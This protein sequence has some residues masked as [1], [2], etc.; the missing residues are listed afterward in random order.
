M[1][2]SSGAEWFTDKG[3]KRIYSIQLD[4]TDVAEYIGVQDLK[5]FSFNERRKR[6]NNV[7]DAMVVAYMVKEGAIDKRYAEARL[8]ELRV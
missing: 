6:M 1:I 3:E 4:E 8:Q 7:A 2:V 5:E